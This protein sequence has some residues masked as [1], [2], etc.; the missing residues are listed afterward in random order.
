MIGVSVN[1][2]QMTSCLG[3]GGMGEAFRA[4][5]AARSRCGDQGVAEGFRERRG[6]LRRFEQE[7]R[8]LAALHHPNDL[9]IQDEGSSYLIAPR[10]CLG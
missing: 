9:I 8:T 4:G 2:Y 3:A 6:L 10:N 5:H 1:H 7:A